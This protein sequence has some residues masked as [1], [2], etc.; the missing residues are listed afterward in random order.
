MSG[1]FKTRTRAKHM[2]NAEQKWRQTLQRN[3][4]TH[5]ETVDAGWVGK[6][7]FMD[8]DVSV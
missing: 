6:A 4:K 1:K 5:F 7:V 8:R 3:V 2:P